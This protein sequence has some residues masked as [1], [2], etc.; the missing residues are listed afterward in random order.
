[1]K[2]IRDTWTE[3]M[4]KQLDKAF[5]KA[6]EDLLLYGN[7]VLSNQNGKI[8]RVDPREVLKDFPDAS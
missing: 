3:S 6:F 4:N 2:D 5:N 7:C 1:M 8:V